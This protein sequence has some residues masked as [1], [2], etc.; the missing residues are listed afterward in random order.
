MLKTHLYILALVLGAGL[1]SCAEATEDSDSTDTVEENQSEATADSET[2][3]E[4]TESEDTSEPEEGDEISSR[5]NYDQDFEIFK[6]AVINKDI[7]G[8][9]AFASSDMIDAEMLVDAFQDPDFLAMLKKATYD[10]LTEDTT[11]GDEVLLVL[12]CMVEGSDDE[13][14]TFESGLYLYFSQ[15]DPSLLLE[16][17]IAAG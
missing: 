6:T 3:T 14:N 11:S 16:N 4:T 5:Y 8:V 15:G 7:K 2:E 9:S 17:F 12:S 1:F 10:D 13:G